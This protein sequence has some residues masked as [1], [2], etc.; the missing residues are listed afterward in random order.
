MT[1]T[2]ARACAAH[3]WR[4]I[5]AWLLAIAIGAVCA[6]AGL[7]GLTTEGEVTNNPDS[8]RAKD[9]IEQRLPDRR[10]RTEL[11]VVRSN[12]PRRSTSPPSGPR[13][14]GWPAIARSTGQ[15]ASAAIYYQRPDP[16][17]VSADRHALLI[18]IR[19]RDE[20][21][22]GVAE[23]GRRHRGVRRA[24]RLQ[25]VDDRQVDA[26]ARPERALPE[27]PQGG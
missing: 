15:S 20:S 26:L 7:G 9:L 10:T 18:P 27:R 5:G 4:T 1:Q 23:L 25:R 6:A 12:Q 19:L 13:S 21:E 22:S 11:V 14:G 24:Q 8:L 17:L 2:L 16:S 3:P